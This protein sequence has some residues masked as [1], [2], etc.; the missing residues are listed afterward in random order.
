MLRINTLDTSELARWGEAIGKE[1]AEMVKDL[2]VSI[3]LSWEADKIALDNLLCERAGATP[4]ELNMEA[5]VREWNKTV[6][7]KGLRL[8]S[9]AIAE[10]SVT[11]RLS[12][13]CFVR[14]RPCPGPFFF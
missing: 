2:E 13:P 9:M 7:W 10:E 1:G 4:K 3:A 8:E 14:R 11:F 5:S 12:D 6:C